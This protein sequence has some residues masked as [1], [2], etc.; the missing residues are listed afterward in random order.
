MMRVWQPSGPLRPSSAPVV[1]R[2]V[3]QIS[4]LTDPYERTQIDPA[5]AAE[6]LNPNYFRYGWRKF[7]FHDYQERHQHGHLCH[8][9]SIASC[10]HKSNAHCLFP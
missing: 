3:R 9:K 6:D 10:T 5:K 1:R 4:S 8:K 2:V 7:F